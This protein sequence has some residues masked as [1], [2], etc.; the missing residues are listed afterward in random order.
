MKPLTVAEIIAALVSLTLIFVAGLLN[1][2]MG[3]TPESG[4]IVHNSR[5]GPIR[6]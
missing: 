1:G 2:L 3:Q 5:S 6:A 4:Q